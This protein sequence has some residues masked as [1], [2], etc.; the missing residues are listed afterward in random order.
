MST[1]FPY[2]Q[3]DTPEKKKLAGKPDKGT[4][5]YRREGS[6]QE[7]GEWCVA[8]QD[9]FDDKFVSPGGVCMFVKSSRAAVHKRMK[10][11]RL[12]AFCF[13]VVTPEKTFFGN[14]RKAKSSPFIF[15][16]VSECKAWAK[17]LE[18]KRGTSETE[19]EKDYN[20]DFLVRDPEDQKNRK[21]RYTDK[22]D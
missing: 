19:D 11:G 2:L 17:E 3:I 5:I 21:V 14:T 16:P 20:D 8:I 4:R 1:E 9:V 13:H 12:T 7:S 6:Y 22:Y 10:E 15:I 18:G